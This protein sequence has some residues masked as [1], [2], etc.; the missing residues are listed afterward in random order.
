[1]SQDI[2]NIQNDHSLSTLEVEIESKG[3]TKCRKCLILC[4][5]ESR[6]ISLSLICIGAAHFYIF[7]EYSMR[8][9]IGF[10]H[11]GVWVFFALAILSWLIVVYILVRTFSAMIFLGNGEKASIAADINEDEQDVNNNENE[12][13]VN[14]NENG[15]LFNF[16]NL[17]KSINLLQK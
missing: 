1:M 7:F 14:N 15:I 9:R 16:H 5:N 11:D 4:G 3:H 12:Q 13:D 6:F 10:Q 17:L 2:V 8:F